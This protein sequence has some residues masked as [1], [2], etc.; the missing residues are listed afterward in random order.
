MK[1]EFDA[2][3]LTTI[4]AAVFTAGFVVGNAFGDW[5]LRV[6]RG[7]LASVRGLDADQMAAVTERVETYRGSPAGVY[8]PYKLAV[9]DERESDDLPERGGDGAT[10]RAQ[11]VAIHTNGGKTIVEYRLWEVSRS[12]SVGEEAAPEY[13]MVRTRTLDSFLN[14]YKRPVAAGFARGRYPAI[15]SP[16]SAGKKGPLS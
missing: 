14:I 10:W 8:R 7:A 15:T 3:E 11:V 12:R 1:Y 16:G 9:G 13:G 6:W 5:F 2:V 4:V